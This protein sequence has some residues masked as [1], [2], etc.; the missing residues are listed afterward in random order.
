MSYSNYSEIASQL[1]QETTHVSNPEL[2]D[3]VNYKNEFA[4]STLEGL[5]GLHVGDK[6]IE[7]I[8]MLR[9][10]AKGLN[11]EKYGFNDEDLAD[12]QSSLE[13]G[14]VKGAIGKLGNKLTGKLTD[15][16]KDAMS[17]VKTKL[18]G[19][20]DSTVDSQKAFAKATSG[21][22]ENTNMVTKSITT[23]HPARDQ[24]DDTP[25]IQQAT[26][27]EDLLENI[28]RSNVRFNNLDSTAQQKVID[29]YTANKTPGAKDINLNDLPNQN[30]DEV[31]QNLISK[32]DAL[33]T[34]EN[35]SQTTFKNPDLQVNPS[36]DYGQGNII[37]GKMNTQAT[38]NNTPETEDVQVPESSPDALSKLVSA[39]DD[40]SKTT[41]DVTKGLAD[42]KDTLEGLTADS[43]AL[44]FDPVNWF[45]SA[46]LG[47]GSLVVGDE[48]K[49]HHKKFI[50]PPNA[51]QSYT[52]TADA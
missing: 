23:P 40:M 6:S 16:G 27:P 41:S 42:T 22:Q 51:I 44:D 52:L 24:I 37:K 1:A 30:L 7:A 26:A 50:T 12:I 9:T 21:V 4:K 47:I 11:M 49:A 10:K 38:F 13:T 31:K 5:G 43:T 34:V 25:D 17:K 29:D 28:N 35:D 3:I 2:D 33:S 14:D 36:D 39:T 8:K 45:I 19:L 18:Q 46:G 48:I 15:A 20:K 32:N